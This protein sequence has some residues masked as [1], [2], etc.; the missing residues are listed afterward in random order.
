VTNWLLSVR[1]TVA[2]PVCGPAV[3]ERKMLGAAGEMLKLK[4]SLMPPGV[5]KVITAFPSTLNGS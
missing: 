3:P 2:S 1:T 5:R 4:L